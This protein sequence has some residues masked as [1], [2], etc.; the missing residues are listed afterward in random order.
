MAAMTGGVAPSGGD[1]QAGR[2]LYRAQCAGCHAADGS[3]GRE[4]GVSV[5]AI[6]WVTLARPR[7]IAPARPAYDEGGFVR[8]VT[9]GID[10]A[11]R[12]LAPAMPRLELTTVQRDS[13]A[14]YIAIIGTARDPEPGVGPTEIRIGAVLPISGNDAAT[15]RAVQAAVTAAFAAAGPIFGRTL[16]LDVEDAGGDVAAAT[17][18]LAHGDRVLALV[19]TLLPKSVDVEMPVVGPLDLLVMAGRGDRLGSAAAATLIEALERV[20]ARPTRALLVG[21]LKTPHDDRVGG[22]E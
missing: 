22:S 17:A 11:G 6:D 20:G 4:G 10:A 14:A 5:P 21:A 13:L 1:A 18:R 19:A 2:V 9:S 15:G 3:G 12:V 8:A 7:I 16:R